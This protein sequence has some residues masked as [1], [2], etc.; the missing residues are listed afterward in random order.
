MYIIHFDIVAV[1]LS[2]ITLYI[3]YKQKRTASIQSR[4][5]ILVIYA[6][7][8]SS[9]TGVISSLYINS[10]PDASHFAVLLSIYIFY[11]IHNSVSICIAGYLFSISSISLSSRRQKVVFLLP[12]IFSMGLITT[13]FLHN[14]IFYIDQNSIYQHGPLLPLLYLTSLIYLFI[15]IWSIFLRKNRISGLHKLTYA[16]AILLPVLGIIIQ[17]SVEGLVLEIFATSISMLFILLTI[18]NVDELKDGQTGLYNRE[19]FNSFLEEYFDHQRLFTVIFHWSPFLSSLHGLVNYENHREISSIY[20]RGL[21]EICGKYNLLCI[22]DNGLYAV[23][24]EGSKD[25]GNAGNVA[26][27]LA[28]QSR[29]L[30]TFSTMNIQ[31]PARQCMIHC[32]EDVDNLTGLV[33]LTGQFVNQSEQSGNRHIFYARDFVLNKYQREAT[34]ADTIRR[35]L[36]ASTPELKYQAIYSADK[37][38]ISGIE[39][40]LSLQLDTGEQIHQSEII[41]IAEKSGLGLRLGLL[42]IEKAVGWFAHNQLQN[43]HDCQ[44][45]IR[46]LPSLSLELDWP[47]LVLQVLKDHGFEPENLCLEITETTAVAAGT[48]LKINM[49]LLTGIGVNFALDDY[50]SGFTDLRQLISLPFTAIKLDKKIIQNGLSNERDRKLLEASVQL[51]KHLNKRITAEGIE[52]EDQLQI[53][54]AMGCDHLQGYYFGRPVPGKEIISSIPTS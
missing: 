41:K 31:I 21:K 14:S 9:I 54:T 15:I 18:Q 36:D 47:R 37:S 11:F 2:L 44:L 30:W 6:L 52:T 3:Y 28:D 43:R 4:H 53:M 25:S 32:P 12:W 29:K 5:F 26:I 48:N 39:A 13:N 7:I 27:E 51:F 24:I 38:I 35:M 23:I 33:D 40:L 10:L 19:A 46:M 34:I 22:L 8:G 50:G 1:I 20:S 45:Q 17:N 49:E 42:M 16:G